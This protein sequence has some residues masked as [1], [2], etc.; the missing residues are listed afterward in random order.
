MKKYLPIITIALFGVSCSHPN[1]SNESQ[2][3]KK[4]TIAKS[5][6]KSANIVKSKTAK[7]DT[8]GDKYPGWVDTLVFS[9]TKHTNNELV[10]YSITHHLKEEWVLDDKEKTD[11]ATYWIFNVGHDV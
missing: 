3:L 4:D 2:T 6:A 5:T 7:P 9:Y 10:K 1:G 11:T 8:A